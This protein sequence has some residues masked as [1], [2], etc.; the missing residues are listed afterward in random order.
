MNY[1]TTDYLEINSQITIELLDSDK[2][3]FY[4]KKLT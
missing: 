4:F 1:L 2:F 3:D